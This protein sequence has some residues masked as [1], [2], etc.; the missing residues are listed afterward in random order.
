MKKTARGKFL[1]A[2]QSYN[3]NNLIQHLSLLSIECFVGSS[4]KIASTAI[5][6]EFVLPQNPYKKYPV[7][8]TPWS[9]VDITYYAAFYC[10]NRNVK[11]LDSRSELLFIINAYNGFHAEEE[12]EHTFMK[13]NKN[14]LST[15]FL[16]YLY[17][18]F[19]EQSRF[20]KV[21]QVFE[22]Y[23]REKYIMTEISCSFKDDINVE[24]NVLSEIGISNTTKNRNI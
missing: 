16:L 12:K 24:Q 4:N 5:H 19:G 6:D 18:F 22:N 17:G 2:I 3:Q 10:N 14:G 21:N 1:Q 20:Q 11:K 7:I 9:L 13:S 23:C 15:D 8:I